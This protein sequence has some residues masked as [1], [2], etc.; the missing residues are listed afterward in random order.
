VADWRD[1]LALADKNLPGFRDAFLG[2]VAEAQKNVD[3]PAL[4]AL[5]A[6]GQY[7]QAASAVELAWFGAAKGWEVDLTE[8]ALALSGQAGKLE[9][10]TILQVVP[11]QEPFTTVKG[12]PSWRFNMV[13]PQAVS[14]AQHESATLV[15]AIGE[16]QLAAIRDVIAAS[17]GGAYAV[18]KSARLIRDVVGLDSRRAAALAGFQSRLQA[19]VAKMQAGGATAAKVAAAQ[20]KAGKAVERYRKRLL[21][22]RGTVIA[23]T[24]TLAAANQGQLEAWRQAR[25]AGRLPKGAQ[26][27]WITTPDDRRCTAICKP[28]HGQKVPLD[29]SFMVPKVGAKPR[30]P[31][32]PQCRCVMS[33]VARPAPTKAP[34]TS[35][36]VPG[37]GG[38]LRPKHGLSIGK[39][40][41][42]KMSTGG[43][44]QTGYEA[45]TGIFGGE[46]MDG[47]LGPKADLWSAQVHSLPAKPGYVAKGPYKTKA[48]ALSAV[49]HQG[50]TGG[51]VHELPGGLWEIHMSEDVAKKAGAALKAPPPPAAPA[52]KIL[53]EVKSHLDATKHWLPLNEQQALQAKVIALEES[54]QQA[55]LDIMQ[56]FQAMN[57]EDALELATQVKAAP[58][59]NPAVLQFGSNLTT[60]AGAEAMEDV[61]KAIYP[62]A[63]AHYDEASHTWV[64]L[65]GP[66]PQQAAYTKAYSDAAMKLTFGGQTANGNALVQVAKGLDEAA[67]AKVLELMQTTGKDFES[68]LQE[69]LLPPKPKFTVKGPY[70]TKASAQSIKGH[71]PAGSP[72]KQATLHELP[73][74]SWELHVPTGATPPA[75]GAVPSPAAAV[76]KAPLT[77]QTAQTFDELSHVLATTNDPAEMVL[78]QNKLK[79]L[80]GQPGQKIPW[81]SAGQT[82]S[83]IADAEAAKL[84]AGGSPDWAKANKILN[85]Q[86][87]QKDLFAEAI[88]GG[89]SVDVA[90]AKATGTYVAPPAP[91]LPMG[92]VKNAKGAPQLPLAPGSSADLKAT[93]K[94]FNVWID[95]LYDIDETLAYTVADD[96]AKLTPPQ[97]KKIVDMTEAGTHTFQEALDEVLAAPKV[98]QLQI[99]PSTP[100]IQKDVYEAVNKQL[101]TLDGAKATQALDDVVAMTDDQLFQLKV[102]INSGKQLDEAIDAVLHP[103]PSPAQIIAEPP[104]TI[105]G[106]GYTVKGPYK[107]KASAQSIKGHAPKDSPLKSATLHENADGTWELHV[108]DPSAHAPQ[109]TAG[110]TVAPKPNLTAPPVYAPPAGKTTAWADDLMKHKVANAK[111]SNPGGVYQDA[112]TGKKYYVKEYADEGQALGEN[113]AN[114]IYLDLGANAPRSYVIRGSDGKLRYISEWMDDVKGTVKN[115][116]LTKETADKILDNFVADVFTANWDAVGT[117]LDN[118]VILGNGQVA[119]IDMGGSLLHRAQG[120]LKPAAGLDTIQEW[121]TFLTHNTYFGQIFQS[122]GLA[123]AD[124][125]GA[126]AIAQIDRVLSLI[127][128]GVAHPDDAWFKYVSQ[129]MPNAPDATKT[130]IAKMLHARAKLLREKRDELVAMLAPPPPVVP[131]N[132]PVGRFY[133]LDEALAIARSRPGAG[134]AIPYDG[135][136]VELLQVRVRGVK[137]A[138]E[139]WTEVKFKLTGDAGDRL[140]QQAAALGMKRG[141]FKLPYQE[142]ARPGLRGAIDETKE[143]ISSSFKTDGHTWTMDKSGLKVRFSRANPG[144]DVPYTFHNQVQVFVRGEPTQ[145]QVDQLMRQ[146]GVTRVGAPTPQDVQQMAENAFVRLFQQGNRPLPPSQ[147]RVVIETAKREFGVSPADLRLVPG[148]LGIPRVEFTEA[149]WKKIQAK[150]GTTHFVHHLSSSSDADA[151]AD[152]LLGEHGGLLS[153]SLR[154][155]EGIG[156]SGMSSTRDVA[157]GG[158]DSVFTRQRGG[159]MPTR[160]SAGTIVIKPSALRRTDWYAYPGDEYGANNPGGHYAGVIQRRKNLANV[161]QHNGSAETM[162]RHIVEWEDVD[163]IYLSASVRND[164]IR[165][166]RARGITHVAGRRVEDFLRV[167]S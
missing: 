31:A 81:G 2:A 80:A 50:L 36:V 3:L 56:K 122:A 72:L 11:A 106:P 114:Q 98:P 65:S 78:A 74:G 70:K 18:D 93:I 140:E 66:T 91:K 34:I 99:F 43:G 5:L 141:N 152:K 59:A 16:D 124:D 35:K 33:L 10:A 153:T 13:S 49:N 29:A 41:V 137:I 30:P 133:D 25:D 47:P 63:T 136:D 118:V 20:A 9:A 149:A 82:S 143:G 131:I 79:A 161:A 142:S 147:A 53:P 132:V 52:L 127:P 112:A 83:Q 113:L 159:A 96:V 130:R 46:M 167:G 90:I 37:T 69:V 62:Q 155:T 100:A 162:F 107:T 7:S 19:G 76:A 71:A 51:T 38:I 64:I 22:Q 108:P 75:P 26:K 163:A 8:K 67:Q 157:T 21:T 134:A 138:N 1:L 27:K 48:S 4:K 94:Q 101:L 121:Q 158:A 23:R 39:S 102:E 165:K 54:E 164:V 89:D 77:A 12:L 24:E 144:D 61:W 110:G 45:Q 60:K 115:I 87:A 92:W 15:T 111:G 117:G 86:P 57:F 32:H 85:L 145:A 6:K 128:Q 154:M 135:G 28:M 166:L 44:Y 88:V 148:P 123:S 73:D 139:D 160:A 109:A 146:F 42:E 55:V 58:A 103:V 151:L 116:G 14:W 119:R 104:P 97:A 126:R 95:D 120:A 105:G 156:R 129:R 17:T 150:T 68:A 125:L 84:V 40:F